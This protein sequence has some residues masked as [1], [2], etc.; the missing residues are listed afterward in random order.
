MEKTAIFLGMNITFLSDKGSWKNASIAALAQR[1]GKK[2]HQVVCL[3]DAETVPRGDLLIILG[4]FKI[5]PAAVLK[6]NKNNL[7]VHESA[8]PKGRG[9]SPVT[10]LVL[11]GAREIPLT[12]FEAV[13]KVDAGNIYLRGKV[14]LKG[15]ELLAEIREKVADTMMRLCETFVADY[16]GILKKGAEQ[17]GKATYYKKR[18]PEDSRLDPKKSIAQQFD[19]LRVVDNE[20]Y[21][22]YFTLRGQTY[23]L[24]IEKKKR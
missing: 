1:L 15:D 11:E 22:A 16:P 24:K 2:G 17:S 20:S 9:W 12:L 10:W 13:E 8:L 23:L 7:V 21:P 4:F 6:R 19:L 5:V 3:H 18:K 14:V